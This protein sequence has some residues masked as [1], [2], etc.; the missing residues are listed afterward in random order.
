[1]NIQEQFEQFEKDL[2]ARYDLNIQ[3]ELS[4]QEKWKEKRRGKFTASNFRLLM[5]CSSRKKGKSWIDPFWLCDFGQTAKEYILKVACERA[6]GKIIEAPT[7]WQMKHGIN[8][9]PQALEKLSEKLGVEFQGS[10]FKEIIPGIAGA[11]PDNWFYKGTVGK[12][13]LID[14]CQ[15]HPS[16]CV[17]VAIE[18][19]GQ[20]DL[21]VYGTEVKCPA[22][23][24]SHFELSNTFIG[25]GHTYF[26]QVLGESFALNTDTVVFATYDPRFP[27][28][29]DLSYQE[30]NLSE[31]HAN[32]LM[33][34]LII[35][36]RIVRE[37]IKS[38]F[39][40]N[41]FE[42]L[43]NAFD[44]LKEESSLNTFISEQI[45]VLS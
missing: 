25:E 14:G 3:E 2:V 38:N 16:N 1:M 35:A 44:L 39:A 10:E 33:V 8:L 19:K 31:V 45:N 30:V 18:I 15:E 40:Y 27:A 37:L 20:D 7:T 4:E 28:P 29:A 12:E 5:S 21:K 34:R 24:W 32:A 11:T 23:L 42:I 22:T 36:E 26:W 6:T 41:S 9:E 13:D 43:D 17:P